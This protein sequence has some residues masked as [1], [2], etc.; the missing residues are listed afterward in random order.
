[1]ITLTGNL[2]FDAISLA[3]EQ[4]RQA[5]YAAAGNQAAISLADV[6]FYQTLLSASYAVNGGANSYQ[7]QEALIELRQLPVTAIPN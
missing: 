3:A 6:M 5:A 1:M 2:A 7:F 4:T